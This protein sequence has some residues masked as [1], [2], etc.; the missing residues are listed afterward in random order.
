MLSNKLQY[1]ASYEND[2]SKIF[3]MYT[4]NL[5]VCMTS[6]VSQNLNTPIK[7]GKGNTWTWKNLSNFAKKNFFRLPWGDFFKPIDTDVYPKNAIE[8]I[9][10]YT[11]HQKWHAGSCDQF[12]WGDPVLKV[13]QRFYNVLQCYEVLWC[14]PGKVKG[15]FHSSPH[16][17]II[18]EKI[19]CCL[20]GDKQKK[21][22][23]RRFWSS[24]CFQKHWPRYLA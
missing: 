18:R 4:C 22:T 20:R 15:F 2:I 14:N 11:H 17:S 7:A 19:T 23:F 1:S 10:A 12:N 24:A 5:Q 16:H 3:T 8:T 6:R 21:R 9:S 13:E